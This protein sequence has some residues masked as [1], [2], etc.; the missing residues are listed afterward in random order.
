VWKSELERAF[1]TYWRILAPQ[2]SEPDCEY[3]FCETRRF[4]FDF[5]WPAQK[6]AVE[7]EGGIW[8]RGRHVRGAGFARDCEKYNLATSL[9]WDV[10]RL[11]GDML[12][13]NPVDVLG[14]IVKALE[15][16]N[17]MQEAVRG[18]MGALNGAYGYIAGDHTAKPS[19]LT[20]RLLTVVD[21]ARDR[22]L[23]CDW[24]PVVKEM[25]NVI[26]ALEKER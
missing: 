5:A 22:L 13:Q 11:T 26:E 23:Q 16:S 7:M 24:L 6:V 25:Y 4:R 14:M 20:N 17:T 19:N 9:S 10:F 8:S 18:S 3:Q 21:A 2:Q 1:L 12:E 15:T